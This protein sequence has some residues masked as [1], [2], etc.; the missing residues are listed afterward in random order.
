MVN[1]IWA[2]F[3]VVGIIYSFFNGSTDIVNTEIISS[4]SSSISMILTILPIMC[5]WLGLM[6]IAK[7]SG[8]LDIM[9]KKISPIVKKLFPE[10]PKNHE[11]LGLI[12][13]NII[14]NML[15]LGNAATPFGLKAM[16]SMQ[17]L[18]KYKDKASRSMI[19]F[20]VINTASVTIIP[21]TVISFRLINGAKN[22]T[23]IVF[24]SIITTFLSCL[25]GLVLDRICYLIWR[26][27]DGY[28]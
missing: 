21:T 17:S 18:N 8:M 16:K 15:G 2:F 25:F 5:L 19:T 3:I 22:P 14:M 27:K 26:R 7:E 24:A 13:S 11:A 12:S 20:L 23:D 4:A 6:N 1:Y 10:I 9:S 28:C